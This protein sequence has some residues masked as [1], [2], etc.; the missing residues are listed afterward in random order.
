MDCAGSHYGWSGKRHPFIA[1]TYNPPI[2][3]LL[4]RNNAT[5]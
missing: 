5:I 2:H 1:S 3:P 4:P